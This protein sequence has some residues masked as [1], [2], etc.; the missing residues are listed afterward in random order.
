MKKFL[1]ITCLIFTLL[2][3]N[4]YTPSVSGKDYKQNAKK[5]IMIDL[6]GVLNNYTK[7]NKDEIPEIRNGAREF[8]EKLH[9]SNNYKLVLFTARSPMLA[10]KWLIK[11][12]LDK[13]FS[14]VT[15]VKYPAFLYIDDRGINFSGDYNEILF[16][17]NQIKF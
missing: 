12:N 17:I 1:L 5:I 3:N 6:D 14:D 15:N 2:I 7:Y 4:I 13:Y 11:N 9:A 8:L 10:T 16:K